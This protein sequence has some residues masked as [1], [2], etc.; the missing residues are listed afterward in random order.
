MCVCVCV[1]VCV[2]NSWVTVTFYSLDLLSAINWSRGSRGPWSQWSAAW[3]SQGAWPL[4][5]RGVTAWWVELVAIFVSR[6]ELSFVTLRTLLKFFWWLLIKYVRV[7]LPQWSQSLG[8]SLSVPANTYKI[9]KA[10]PLRCLA[11]RTRVH[12]G[13]VL[14][15][16]SWLAE[17]QEWF[18]LE[19]SV[20][21][22]QV[23]HIWK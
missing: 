12:F 18:L 2:F 17:L 16:R 5:L 20:N 15:M 11:L 4:T 13:R 7:Y 22:T 23:V 9:V 8:E 6:A 19:H 3:N 21:Q 1:C 10:E 14:C